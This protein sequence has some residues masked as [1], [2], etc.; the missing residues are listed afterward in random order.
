MAA[1]DPLQPPIT[2]FIAHLSNE[3]QLSPHTVDGYRRDLAALK[4]DLDDLSIN[5]W[6]D[7]GAHHIRTHISAGYRKGRTGKTLQRHLSAIRTFFNYLA[8]EGICKANPAMEFSAPKSDSRL[9]VT[10]DTDQV[11]RLLEINTTDW[12][13]LRDRA[14][15]ELFYSSG[16]R[17]AELVGTNLP[18]ISFDDNSIKVRGKGSKERISRSGRRYQRVRSKT[19]LRCSSVNAGSASVTVMSRNA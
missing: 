6:R 8:R 9:P 17:L 3:R 1:D 5:D 18:D 10:I 2:A 4:A 7:V 16:L 15:L 12:H 11:S 14:M 13:G 19:K